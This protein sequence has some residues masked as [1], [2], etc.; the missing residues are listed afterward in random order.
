MAVNPRVASR[1][2][3]MKESSRPLGMKEVQAAQLK[4]QL[5][6]LATMATMMPEAALAEGLTPSLKAFLGSVV[7]GLV[8]VA[9]IITAFSFAAN[10]DETAF[11]GSANTFK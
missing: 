8:V 11:D 10:T 5:F 6:A 7:A 1:P 9:G 2:V 4:K 3:V